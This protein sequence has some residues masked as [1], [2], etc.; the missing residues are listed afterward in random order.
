M[1][2]TLSGGYGIVGKSQ[3]VG[4]KFELLLGEKL[5]LLVYSKK[6]FIY[7]QD[8]RPETVGVGMGVKE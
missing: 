4:S 1:V 2:E 7:S 6:V 5:V 3:L 8:V